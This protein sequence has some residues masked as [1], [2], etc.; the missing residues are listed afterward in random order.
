MAGRLCSVRKSMVLSAR[1]PGRLSSTRGT[2]LSAVDGEEAQELG[3]SETPSLAILDLLMPKMGGRET[4]AK[5][6]QQFEKLPVLFTSGYSEE[7]GGLET[8]GHFLQ[9]PLSPTRLGPMV[10][11]ILDQGMATSRAH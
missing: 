2:V 7:S 8:R 6:A 11:G 4:A 3:E 10:R 5:L 9:K 1:W